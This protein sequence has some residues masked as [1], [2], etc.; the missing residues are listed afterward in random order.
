MSWFKT[1]I[2]I[3]KPF[4]AGCG[5][6]TADALVRYYYFNSSYNTRNNITAKYI[7]HVKYLSKCILI[8]TYFYISI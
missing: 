4:C 6:N 8:G 7:S 2:K 3:D 5:K 1:E